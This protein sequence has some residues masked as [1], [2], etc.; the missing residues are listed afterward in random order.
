MRRCHVKG[1]LAV[2]AVGMVV[3]RSGMTGDRGVSGQHTGVVERA[4]VPV[5]LRVCV[6]VRRCGQLHKERFSGR[7]PPIRGGGRR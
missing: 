7:N 3:G 2:A 5:H 4:G 1:V 6:R